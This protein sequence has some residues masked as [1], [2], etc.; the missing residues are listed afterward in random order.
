MGN[1]GNTPASKASAT[2]GGS[3]TKGNRYSTG[4]APSTATR[5]LWATPTPQRIPVPGT[6]NPGSVR[7][8]PATPRA[9]RHLA[10]TPATPPRTQ[11]NPWATP[12]P[13]KRT[14]DAL[15]EQAIA[16]LRPGAPTTGARGHQGAPCPVCHTTPASNGACM[17]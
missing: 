4:T 16:G 17:C 13:S 10:N 8:V 11:R 6:G 3:A 5:A 15:A 1:W 7:F 2:K 9:A 12:M 14:L